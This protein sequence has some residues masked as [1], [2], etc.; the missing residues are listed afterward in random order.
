MYTALSF[1]LIRIITLMSVS[2]EKKLIKQ[3]NLLEPNGGSS[4]NS[5]LSGR[6]FSAPA[7]CQHRPGGFSVQPN[8]KA[9]AKRLDAKFEWKVSSGKKITHQI[10]G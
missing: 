3:I 5:A 7:F 6:E 4:F 1:I 9:T 2:K 10:I 8:E